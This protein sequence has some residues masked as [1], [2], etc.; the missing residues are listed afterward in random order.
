M[1]AAFDAKGTRASGTRRAEAP[2]ATN[3][4]A[5]VLPICLPAPKWNRRTPRFHRE[6]VQNECRTY[7]FLPVNVTGARYSKIFRR[8]GFV[9]QAFIT[10]LSRNLT[11]TPLRVLGGNSKLAQNPRERGTIAFFVVHFP[12]DSLF[13]SRV[14]RAME[15]R[16]SS[17]LGR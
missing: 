8:S 16:S 15:R 13:Q 3:G 10:P 9:S 4:R 2:L 17:L 12:F 11:D 1:P 6:L 7:A 5:H 14:Q